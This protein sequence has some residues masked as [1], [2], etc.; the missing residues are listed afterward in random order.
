MTGHKRFDIRILIKYNPEIKGVRALKSYFYAVIIVLLLTPGAFALSWQDTLATANTRSNSI[1]S[2]EKQSEA[3][4]WSWVRSY[5]NFLP[6]FSGTASISQTYTA[7]N[8]A[9]PQMYSYGLNATQNLFTGFGNYFNLQS[10]F[11]QYE[12]DQANLNKARS[13]SYYN[14]RLAFI[15]LLIA[16]ENLKLQNQILE[17]RRQNE[18]M[19]RL[20]YEGGKEDKGNLMQNEA[21]LAD[22]EYSV[23]SAKRQLRLAQA[24]LAQLLDESIDQIDQVEGDLTATVPSTPEY[25]SLAV[26]TPSYQIAKYQLEQ[27]EIGNSST[28][29]G[30]LPDISLQGSYRKTGLNWPPDS[31]NKSLSLNLSYNFFP[32]GT[33]LAD[34]AV[35]G[36]K[37]DKARQDFAQSSKS[38]RYGI[39]EAYENL[40]DAVESLKVKKLYLEAA[41]ER[42]KIAQVEYL[43]GL[44]NY[45]NWDLIESQ[46]ISAQQ[47]LINAQRSALQNEAAW[48]NS[49]GGWVK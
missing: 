38:I 26:G 19:I 4:R 6:Q 10:A 39:E 28:V 20:N 11:V 25:S 49:Y 48:Q 12:S 18:R 14:C 46:Y 13:D 3:S 32:G 30:F 36:S 24:N 15:N 35:N 37:L 45:T 21:Y 17:R 23:S 1:K 33:N 41:K 29:S 8:A 40:K 43:N 27:A 22:A 47:T 42:E 2:A 9:S 5:G 16:Q 44:M 31:E 34:I 7:S